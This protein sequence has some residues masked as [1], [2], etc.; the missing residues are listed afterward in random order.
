MKDEGPMTASQALLL[1]TE[2]NKIKGKNKTTPEKDTYRQGDCIH[3]RNKVQRYHYMS[4]VTL[5]V[6]PDPGDGNGSRL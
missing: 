6:R 5:N 1:Q 3:E 4:S 2:E